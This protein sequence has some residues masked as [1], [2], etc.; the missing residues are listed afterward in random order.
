[1][2]GSVPSS[3]PIG[4]V[5]RAHGAVARASRRAL[6]AG[7]AEHPS[8]HVM[9][10]AMAGGL[11]MLPLLGACG[12]TPRDQFMHDRAVSFGSQ[13]GDGR[14]VGS[15]PTAHVFPERETALTGV[16]AAEMGR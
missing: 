9:R 4:G 8:R 15:D 1:M 10:A 14:L 2:I 7:R 12:W 6:E 11:L 16:A 5:R 3:G 13:R